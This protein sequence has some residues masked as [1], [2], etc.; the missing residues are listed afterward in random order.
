MKALDDSNTAWANFNKPLIAAVEGNCF[1]GGHSIVAKADIAVARKG[2]L[3]GFPEILRGAFPIMVQVPL[4]NLIPKKKFL[5]QL[6]TGD[7]ITAEE[8]ERCNL[9]MPSVLMKV[10]PT[11]IGE[12]F[13]QDWSTLGNTNG[14]WVRPLT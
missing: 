14:R 11:Y 1:A 12:S 6:F 4:V 8:A 2:V 13:R 5:A 9:L 7:N 10:S 3:F